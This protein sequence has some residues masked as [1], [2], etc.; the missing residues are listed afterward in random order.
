MFKAQSEPNHKT[1]GLTWPAE[2]DSSLDLV[3]IVLNELV[4]NRVK[5]IKALCGFSK[6]IIF[7]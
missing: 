1:M 3:L 4:C 5:P 6:L 7:G 2:A